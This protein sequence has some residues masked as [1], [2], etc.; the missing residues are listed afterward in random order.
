MKISFKKNWGMSKAGYYHCPLLY[1]AFGRNG[2]TLTIIGLSLLV[3]WT[4]KDKEHP[5]STF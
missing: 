1:F 3:A 5:V 2:F 4:I